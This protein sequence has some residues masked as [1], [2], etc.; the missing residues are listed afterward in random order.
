MQTKKVMVA[1]SGGVDSS[2]AAYLIKQQALE[3]IGATLKLFNNVDVAVD[4][5]KTCCSLRDVEDARAVATRLDIPYY[6]LNFVDY[7]KKD[8]IERFIASYQAAQTPNPCID[9]NRYI[10]FEKMLRR[11]REIGFDYLAT[12]H[13][14]QIEQQAV[15]GRYLLKKARDISKDQTY[16]LYC[17]TQAQL[18]Q[19]IFP[20]GQLSK[21]EVRQIA[22]AQ[23][24]VTAQK[25]ESQDICFVKNSSY[26]DF[27]KQYTGEEPPKGEIVDKQGK[28]LGEHQGLYAYTIGQRK[29][30]GLALPTPHYVCAKDMDSNRLI[31]GSKA[32]LMQKTLIAKDVNLIS[33]ATIQGRVKVLAKAR[34]NQT[35]Q[36]AWLEQIDQDSYLVEFEQAQ[37]AITPGQAVVFYQGEYVLG[38]G[39]IC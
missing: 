34:Y 33:C 27:I 30:I 9:C 29:K 26:V 15:T 4:T 7:F 35:E 5:A 25:Q 11:A 1:M 16:F 8:V 14:A 38:G 31:I 37:A 2:V 19:T 24:F 10:K 18:A 21:Q 22:R 17:L 3:T 12:G 39:T 13:Y 23:N 20:L 28:V 32:E 36:P 6:V